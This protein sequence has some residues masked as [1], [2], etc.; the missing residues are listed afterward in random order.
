MMF[1]FTDAS[2]FAATDISA[3]VVLILPSFH[4]KLAAILVESR[5]VEPLS[6]LRSILEITYT[7]ANIAVGAQRDDPIGH[8]SPPPVSLDCETGRPAGPKPIR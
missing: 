7:I 2:V 6:K 4:R 5:G 8:I 1:A 3:E